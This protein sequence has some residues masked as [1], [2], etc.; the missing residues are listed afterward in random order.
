MT[1][2][3]TQA[4]TGDPTVTV[5]GRYLHSKYDPRREAERVLRSARIDAATTVL[6]VLGEGIPYLSRLIAENRSITVY[7]LTFGGDEEPTGPVRTIPVAEAIPA[8]LRATLRGSLHPLQATGVQAIVWPAAAECLGEWIIT[9]QDVVAAALYDLRSELATI[10][11]FGN[12]WI[13]NTLRRSVATSTRLDVAVRS[14]ELILVAGG[15]SAAA[16]VLQELP[17]NLPPVIAAGSA[18]ETLV[19]AGIAPSVVFHTDA[20]F[21]AQRYRIPEMVKTGGGVV[22]GDRGSAPGASGRT[23]PKGGKT[24][25]A[26]RPA[27]RRVALPLRAAVAPGRIGEDAPILFR[28]GTFGEALAPDAEELPLVPE[29]P[30]VAATII[31]FAQTYAPHGELTL[32]GFDLCSY[33]TITHGRPHPNERYIGLHSTRLNPAMTVRALRSGLLTG[34]YVGRWGDGAAAFQTEALEAFQETIRSYI[35]R[36]E[37]SGRVHHLRPSPIWSTAP[38]G[39]APAAANRSD[40]RIDYRQYRRHDLR[41]RRFH[42]RNVLAEWSAQLDDPFRSPDG[43][44]ILLH[45]APV[46]TLAALRG[47]RDLEDAVTDARNRITSFARWVNDE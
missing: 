10:A 5:D 12:L 22:L 1:R 42:A 27:L 16:S 15:P 47:G 44:D 30:T 46:A 31:A 26:V 4:R 2:E 40:G 29:A 32:A 24:D 8:S 14:R 19:A 23:A 39:E 3:T 35:A 18:A 6:F 13:K 28:Q 11:S 43:R 38:V 37:R 20:G 7:A 21:W 41:T 34:S 17:E 33:D 36:Y 25:A 45:L 9:L